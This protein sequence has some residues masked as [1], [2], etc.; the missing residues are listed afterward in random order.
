MSHTKVGEAAA[1]GSLSQVMA[2]VLCGHV[3]GACHW[4]MSLNMCH[5]QQNFAIPESNTT[6]VISLWTPLWGKCQECQ[7]SAGVCSPSPW[8]ES[9][10]TILSLLSPIRAELWH[11][12]VSVGAW[13]E[14]V[15]FHISSQ[16]KG[17][18][19]QSGWTGR[20]KADE[21]G[22]RV[23][24]RSLCVTTPRPVTLLGHS[25]LKWCSGKARGEMEK[26]MNQ[27]AKFQNYGFIDNPKTRTHIREGH[28]WA[29]RVFDQTPAAC[30]PPLFW[31]HNAEMLAGRSHEMPQALLY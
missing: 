11:P 28:P 18:S 4:D 27:S 15:H 29:G 9:Q 12:C 6:A 21:A 31:H 8:S 10:Q 23:C 17:E 5:Q 30:F 13:N 19:I 20:H 14:N 16:N 3:N 24:V 26:L 25:V 2:D 1:Q 22:I 7:K